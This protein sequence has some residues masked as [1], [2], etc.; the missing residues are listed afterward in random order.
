MSSFT[1]QSGLYQNNEW[2]IEYEWA[3]TIP[4]NKSTF[5]EQQ[6]FGLIDSACFDRYIGAF[7]P[8]AYL[9]SVPPLVPSDISLV[10]GTASG[11]SLERASDGNGEPFS[12]IHD[13]NETLSDGRSMTVGIQA[14]QLPVNR[15]IGSTERGDYQANLSIGRY[16]SCLSYLILPVFLTVRVERMWASL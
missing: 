12:T 3:A 4:R 5:M 9:G 11:K 6:T 8:S 7:A 13:D 15:A 2:P 10:P 16:I 14:M 1:S